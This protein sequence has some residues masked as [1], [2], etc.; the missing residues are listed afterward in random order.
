[1]E[2]SVL[3]KLAVSL[4][5]GLLLGLE[6]ERTE[7][8]VAGIRTF[9]LISLMGTICGLLGLQFGGWVV[10]TGLAALAVLLVIANF[11]RVKAGD[12][13]PGLTTEFAATLL[14]GVGAY[15]A[16]GQTSVAVALGGTIA[17]LLHLKKPMHKLV[18]SIGE[19]HIKAIM[20]FVLVAL[21][22]LPLLP[23]QDYG[24]YGAF[25][26]FKTWLFVVLVVGLSLGGY[27]IYQFVGGKA[28]TLLNGILG[29]LISST[30]TTI[31]QARQSAEAGS[32]RWP[33]ALII[34]VASTVLYARVLVLIAIIAMEKFLQLGPPLAVMTAT[35]GIIVAAGFRLSGKHPARM[36]PPQN[37]AELKSAL[38][39]GALYAVI[40]LAAAAA[41]E[42]FGSGGGTGCITISNKL[43]V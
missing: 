14:Y 19:K 36:T 40:R 33:V 32:A 43:T 30:A 28:G 42:H 16:Y 35:C 18:A 12:I 2:V 9:A 7:A 6:R 5:L 4:A 39:L 22:I 3:I 31:S 27:M 34:M 15:L 11:A 24:P 1:M 13:D 29:G 38:I 10:A 21:V 8:S 23:N 37:P 20:R 41:K 25:N 17:L 26:P